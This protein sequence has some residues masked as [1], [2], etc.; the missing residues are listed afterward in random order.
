MSIFYE[1]TN[2]KAVVIEQGFTESKNKNAVFY[3]EVRPVEMFEDGEM[4]AL[5]VDSYSRTIR[6]TITAKT[7]DFTVE[8]LEAIGFAGNGFSDLDPASEGFH[9]FVGVE[10]DVYCKHE[11]YDGKEHERWDV[12]TRPARKP[13]E[14]METSK[15]KKLDALYGNKFKKKPK[16]ATPP[17][18][19]ETVPPV[20]DDD[21][22]P[23]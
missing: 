8:K 20:E 11:A 2:Y 19:R 16:N 18:K 9:N 21:S 10:L 12:S 14:P 6:W 1:A 15:M 3:L 22:I 5:P 7:I 13:V 17:P 23:F 4:K